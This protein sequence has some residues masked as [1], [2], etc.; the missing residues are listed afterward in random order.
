[1]FLNSSAVAGTF[2]AERLYFAAIQARAAQEAGKGGVDHFASQARTAL[3]DSAEM[4]SDDEAKR[5]VLCRA[6]EG[7]LVSGL[8]CA[9]TNM[10]SMERLSSESFTEA[11]KIASM[12]L[13]NPLLT[14]VA[15]ECYADVQRVMARTADT[16]SNAEAYIGK[17]REYMS[18]AA[19][20]WMDIAVANFR[21]RNRLRFEDAIYAAQCDAYV[22]GDFG[23]L[24]GAYELSGLYYKRHSPYEAG[25]RYMARAAWA[26]A[27]SGRH[28]DVVRSGLNAFGRW[29]VE[30]EP[31]QKDRLNVVREAVDFYNAAEN[32]YGENKEGDRLTILFESGGSRRFADVEHLAIEVA[33]LCLFGA[34]QGRFAESCQT[35]FRKK[36][37]DEQQQIA[38]AVA[39]KILDDRAGTI[40][41]SSED[42]TVP[43]AK[44]YEEL[45]RELGVI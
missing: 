8:M 1:L 44:I 3:V 30:L 11:L 2:T 42:T 9:G 6:F 16:G 5:E 26:A 18:M 43:H 28:F 10:R 4:V 36:S 15:M 22:A 32:R 37:S 17:D 7:F 45:G 20:R 25:D 14:A 13:E 19:K 34:A 33:G 38:A 27:M 41:P 23:L 39:A 35:E 29:A 24:M 12:Q 40:D 21:S 31:A